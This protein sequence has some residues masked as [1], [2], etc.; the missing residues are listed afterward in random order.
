MT[1]VAAARYEITCLESKKSAEVTKN[2][3]FDWNEKITDFLKQS[4]IMVL[5]KT[6][7]NERLLV[8]NAAGFD[9]CYLVPERGMTMAAALD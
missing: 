7:K 9:A 4:E 5:K 8:L 6:K 2:I 3:P 1:I